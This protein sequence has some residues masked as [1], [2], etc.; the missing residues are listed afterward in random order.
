MSC[1]KDDLIQKYIDGEVTVQEI[2]RIENHIGRCKECATKI[3]QQRK[4]AE[5]VKDIVNQLGENPAEVPEMIPVKERTRKSFYRR[6]LI[7]Y[8][9]AA[10]CIIIFVLIVFRN[11]EPEPQNMIMM[12][13]AFASDVDANR[14]VSKQSIIIQVIDADGRV[15]EYFTGQEESLK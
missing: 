14:P 7:F 2:A 9:L 13:P 10:A 1:I 5:V 11:K 3:V 4:R 12:V 6:R 15:S 8:D